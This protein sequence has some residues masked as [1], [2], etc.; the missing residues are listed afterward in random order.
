[1]QKLT[2]FVFRL[3]Q[4]TWQVVP[5]QTVDKLHAEIERLEGHLASHPQQRANIKAKLA[6]LQKFMDL[7][8]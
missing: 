5:T 6:E 4:G 8:G 1:M 2:D 3:T 7:S